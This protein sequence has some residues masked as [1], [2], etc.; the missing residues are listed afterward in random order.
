MQI[1]ADKER[2]EKLAAKKRKADGDDADGEA[3]KKQ[4]TDDKKKSE[5]EVTEE[6][7]GAYTQTSEQPDFPILSDHARHRTIPSGSRRPL[8]G[9]DGAARQRRI[10]A[11]V[12]QFTSTNCFLLGRIADPSSTVALVAADLCA[13]TRDGLG[14]ADRS[15]KLSHLLSTPP[16]CAVHL[17]VIM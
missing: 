2:D 4:S 15:A 6:D 9:P 16:I 5:F 7:M 11:L 14:S 3:R 12:K 13:S 1:K 17:V 8:R 10:A